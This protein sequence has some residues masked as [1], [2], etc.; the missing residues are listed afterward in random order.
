MAYLATLLSKKHSS[1]ATTLSFASLFARSLSTSI[2]PKSF[3]SDHFSLLQIESSPKS[4][5]INFCHLVVYARC[6]C[7]TALH[8]KYV[9]APKVSFYPLLFF[10]VCSATDIIFFLKWQVLLRYK[11]F[12]SAGIEPRASWYR[13]Y[14]AYYKTTTTAKVFARFELNMFQP[15]LPKYLSLTETCTKSLHK[16]KTGDDHITILITYFILFAQLLSYLWAISC[17]PIWG[18]RC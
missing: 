5:M 6:I 9:K 17:S 10:W 2:R 14:Y 3:Q 16:C 8:I 11:S 1:S 12:E 15:L 7:P 18:F 13:A 4:F